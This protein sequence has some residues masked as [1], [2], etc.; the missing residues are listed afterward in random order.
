[1]DTQYFGLSSFKVL[2][3][4][5]LRLVEFTS[6]LSFGNKIYSDCQHSGTQILGYEMWNDSNFQNSLRGFVQNS[7]T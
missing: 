5:T 3:V 2:T 1:M 7:I 6:E 4:T